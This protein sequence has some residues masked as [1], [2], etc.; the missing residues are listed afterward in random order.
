MTDPI[1]H[2]QSWT[3]TF[4]QDYKQR[5]ADPWSIS[6]TLGMEATSGSNR[7]SQVHWVHSSFRSKLWWKFT[8]SC[9]A[10]PKSMHPGALA[11]CLLS[12]LQAT[13]LPMN[14]SA[15]V[16]H[17][18]HHLESI[19]TDLGPSPVH[20]WKDGKKYAKHY[21]VLQAWTHILWN[22]NFRALVAYE[23]WQLLMESLGYNYFEVDDNIINTFLSSHWI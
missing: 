8:C 14:P 21:V 13:Q 1:H 23:I 6:E 12:H 17:Y 18:P 10:F 3:L 2:A 16:S 22:Y 5:E 15:A 19:F 4:S 9:I 20:N 11:G 7:Q